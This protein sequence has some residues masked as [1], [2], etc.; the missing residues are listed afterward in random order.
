MKRFDN[1]KRWP[2]QTRSGVPLTTA[3]VYI[4][5]MVPRM[6]LLKTRISNSACVTN[7]L[8]YRSLPC[9]SIHLDEALFFVDPV[10]VRY[11]R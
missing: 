5:N 1:G 7:L 11:Y 3:R 10:A 4:L 2:V 6:N 9:D 8:L